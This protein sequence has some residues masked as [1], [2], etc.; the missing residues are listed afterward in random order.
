[1]THEGGP[2]D[3]QIKDEE[4]INT[5]IDHQN[6]DVTNSGVSV[7]YHPEG[8]E[9]VTISHDTGNGEERTTIRPS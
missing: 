2:G 3:L 8:L 7:E 9:R 1:M 4:V 6:A 5:I